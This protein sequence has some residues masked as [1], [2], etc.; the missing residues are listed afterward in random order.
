[1]AT[2]NIVSKS[3]VDLVI[4]LRF[5]RQ[6]QDIAEAHQVLDALY[7]AFAQEGFYPYRLDVDHMDFLGQ[8]ELNS[9]YIKILRSI[10]H[11]FDPHSIMMPGRYIS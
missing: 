11:V 10:K 3:A 4:A 6:T 7:Q 9:A 8:Q 5:K 2:M 1:M